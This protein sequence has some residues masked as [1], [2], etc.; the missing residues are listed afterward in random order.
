MV[1][2]VAL[3][4]DILP[5][6][7]LF[8]FDLI[9]SQQTT[10][11]KRG[12]PASAKTAKTT[13]T[14]SSTPNLSGL[15]MKRKSKERKLGELQEKRREAESSIKEHQENLS[16]AKGQTVKD[17]TRAINLMIKDCLKKTEDETIELDDD[18]ET[19]SNHEIAELLRATAE[20]I[21]T[22]DT[23]KT[24]ELQDEL[25]MLDEEI[26]KLEDEKKKK[27]YDELKKKLAE[28]EADM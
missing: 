17:A 3:R 20:M 16:K 27:A 25:N 4:C 19:S 11:A 1:F 26:K 14:P 7:L 18:E 9:I 6:R 2:L 22:Q 21:D 10:P 15:K 5:L 8:L 12:R 24:V 23:P 28:L 13:K